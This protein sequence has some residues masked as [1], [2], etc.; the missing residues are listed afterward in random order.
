VKKDVVNKGLVNKIDAEVCI[1]G[2]GISGALC[3]LRLADCFE[4]IVIL[5][6]GVRSLGGS[7]AYQRSLAER[8]DPSRCFPETP[9]SRNYFT[10]KRDHVPYE[11][12]LGVVG[13]ATNAWWGSAGRLLP[14]DFKMKSLYGV[15]LDWPIDYDELEPYLCEAEQ[16]MSIAGDINDS[17]W[18]QSRPYPQPAHPL[19]PHERL[20]ADRIEAYGLKVVTMPTARLSLPLGARPACGGTGTCG[21]CPDEAKYTCSNTHI[22]LIDRTPSIELRPG[23]RA[24]LLTASGDRVEAVLAQDEQGDEVIIRAKVFV[25]AANAFE[26]VRILLNSSMHDESF[27][28]NHHTGR[29]FHEHPKL[30]IKGQAPLDLKRGQGPTPMAGV[31]HS[32]ADG[33]FRSERAAVEVATYDPPPWADDHDMDAPF[34]RRLRDRLFG[35]QLFRRERRDRQGRFWLNC[36]IDQLPDPDSVI[37]LS[38]TRRDPFGWP[39]LEIDVR[40]WTDYVARGA[41]HWRSVAEKIVKDLRGTAEF[42][43]QPAWVHHEGTHLM[44]TSPE[45]S[46]VDGNLRYHHYK[47]LFLL[48]QGVMP[49]GG[50]VSP[51]VTLAGLSL[52]C[53]RFIKAQRAAF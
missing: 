27:R 2:S 39:I 41:A 24:N 30:E 22:P 44:G 40:C 35:E 31:T 43:Q 18:P 10:H 33:A 8:R 23:V 46:V 48:G 37:R 21:A 52:R 51:T 17:P 19:S 47:N 1:V 42:N 9:L 45:N 12:M 5:E 14:S 32:L 7:H 34:V 53:A 6:K 36:Q 15:G 16:E 26:N 20:I 49:T 28:A 11:Y 25:L 50:V 3:A 38:A 13:G 4:R 29:N